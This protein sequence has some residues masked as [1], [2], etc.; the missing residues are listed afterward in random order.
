M[1][2]GG[3]GV[4]VFYYLGPCDMRRQMDGLSAMVR[5]ELG[6]DPTT[7]DLFVFRNRRGDLCKV[8]FYDELGACLLM[9]RLF[10]GSFRIETND[11]SE[12]VS[13]E[14]THA[15]LASLLSQAKITQNKA[16]SLNSQA[17]V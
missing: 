5:S 10:R 7:G 13:I 12:S 2:M 4:R 11:E 17:H 3:R 9:K 16:E 15:D 1:L 6:K 14:L 8:L